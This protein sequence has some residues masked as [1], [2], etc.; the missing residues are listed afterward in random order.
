MKNWRPKGWDI[1]DYCSVE[2]QGDSPLLAMKFFEAGADAMLEVLKNTGSLM[3][4]EQMKLI[5][6]DRK[7]SYGWLVFIPEEVKE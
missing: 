3:S 4:P 1:M 7:Y 6:P 5:V 2:D